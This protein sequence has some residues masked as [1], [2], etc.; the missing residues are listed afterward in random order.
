MESIRAWASF[1]NEDEHH[2]TILDQSRQLSFFLLSDEIAHEYFRFRAL[3][4]YSFG[5]GFDEIFDR[6]W[7]F[8]WSSLQ[9]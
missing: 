8:V 6:V 5:V 7:M 2:Q 4:L 3:I 9:F 1:E